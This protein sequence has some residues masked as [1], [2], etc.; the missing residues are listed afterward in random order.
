L[1]EAPAPAVEAVAPVIP[2]EPVVDMS[3]GLEKAGLQLVETVSKPSAPIQEAPAQ[4][5]GRKPKAPVI[6]NAE[7]L[8]MVE[9]GRKD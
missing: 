9:T 2:A 5:L 6:V 7:P 4:P 1:E 8:Q 3:A